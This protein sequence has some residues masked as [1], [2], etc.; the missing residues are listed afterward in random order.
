MTYLKNTVNQFDLSA[1]NN[2]NQ[3]TIRTLS[4]IGGHNP[5]RAQSANGTL[6]L[7]LQQGITISDEIPGTRI[8]F[9]N[10]SR[11]R[12]RSN[13]LDYFLDLGTDFLSFGIQP[14]VEFFLPVYQGV[15][16]NQ[17]FTGNGALNQS[18]AVV[19]PSTQDIDNN[20]VLVRVNSTIWTQRDHLFDMLPAENAYV[21]RTGFNGGIEIWFG[22]NS[23]GAVPQVGDQIE[24]EY[25][26]TD[27][28]DGNILNTTDNDWIFVDEVFDAF[29]GLVDVENNFFVFIS[30][31]V[32]FG[33]DGESIE[34][35]KSIMPFISRNFVLARPEQFNFVL[36]RL[37]IFSQVDAYTTEKG[38]QFDN[39]NPLDDSIVYLFLV[40]N[41]RLFLQANTTVNYFNL[42]I[43]AFTLDQNEQT[44]IIQYLNSQGTVGV[45][46]GV[47]IV[48]PQIS[49]YVLTISLF[50][51]E[52]V[53]QPAVRDAVLDALS[54]YFIDLQR[55]DRIPKSDLIR[56]VEQVD[57]VD[58]VSVT[59]LS[60]RNEEY[61]K[62]NIDFVESVLQ[63]DPT[64]DP[65]TVQL[66]GY[67]PDRVLG[68]D[69]DLNDILISKDE[70]ALIRGGWLDRFNNNY[71][72]MP[73][74][75]GLGSVNFIF[76]GTTRRQVNV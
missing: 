67:D 13:N 14:G 73:R 32:G 3:R 18:Y 44:K 2:Q 5:V 75:Q 26:V 27:G 37:N 72:D 10:K 36:R 16:R 12:N 33:S 4:I 69:P 66:D 35:T 11:I 65:A 58:S 43:N 64:A 6:R 52:D 56:V 28:A 23:F 48:Q 62:Q 76:K 71:A 70:L 54:T 46:I 50:I 60:Q 57:G 30:D 38:T 51:F 41:F 22:N 45:G 39:N 34:F 49:R 9:L 63:A 42:D 19:V 53:T 20:R 15:I 31:E 55:R 61:H 40:P 47:R 68:L 74:N 59:I 7:Q 29:G 8:T 24:V 25:I 1:P 21:V 17:V